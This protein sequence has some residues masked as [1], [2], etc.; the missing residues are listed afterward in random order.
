MEESVEKQAGDMVAAMRRQAI[1]CSLSMCVMSFSH[2]QL[3]R[4]RHWKSTCLAH[5]KGLSLPGPWSGHLPDAVPEG[6]ARGGPLASTPVES[7]ETCGQC[8]GSRLSRALTCLGVL[9]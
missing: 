4:D 8:T 6:K 1:P 9:C 2:R 3:G 7:Q 5:A